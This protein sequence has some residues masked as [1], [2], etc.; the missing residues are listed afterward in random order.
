VARAGLTFFARG[1]LVERFIDEVALCRVAI[2]KFGLTARD[3]IGQ[4][5]QCGLT[6]VGDLEGLGNSRQLFA[7]FFGQIQDDSSCG[8]RSPDGGFVVSKMEPAESLLS[9][10]YVRLD[11]SA[12]KLA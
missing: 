4:P 9:A 5:D 2:V 10:Q 11:S 6:N 3:P 7:H 12:R 8:H 1:E